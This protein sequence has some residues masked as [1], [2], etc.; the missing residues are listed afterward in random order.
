MSQQIDSRLIETLKEWGIKRLPQYV[1]L[2]KQPARLLP[3][4]LL[5]YLSLLAN[6]CSPI[7][8]IDEEV[9]LRCNNKV[10]AA[11]AL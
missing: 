11:L 6:G 3:V 4:Q 1:E 10:L 5:F 9:V 8:R 2:L 7:G